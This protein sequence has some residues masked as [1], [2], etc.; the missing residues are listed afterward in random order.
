MKTIKDIAKELGLSV[1]TVSKA[2]NNKSDVKRETRQKVLEE[3][4]R[5]NYTPNVNARSLIKKK[6]NMVGLMLSDITDPS[7]SEVALGIEEVLS[8]SGYQLIYGNTFLEIKKEK[9]FLKS[10]LERKIDGIIMK[11]SN[12]NEELLNTINQLKIPIVFLRSLGKNEQELNIS[13][14]DVNHYQATY[15]VVEYLVK[16][17]HRNI[18]FIGMTK[19]SREEEDRFK[20]YSDCL[21]D[22]NINVS[23]QNITIPGTKIIDGGYGIRNLLNKNPNITAVFAA[24]DLLAIGALDWLKERNYIVPNDISVIGFDNLEISRLHIINLTTVDL[25]RKEMGRQAAE[26]LLDMLSSEAINKKEVKLDTQLIIRNTSGK[27]PKSIL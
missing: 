3:M 19:E 27:N 12:L 15:N 8:T 18:G 9:D 21:K 5:I 16:L 6:T 11:P 26:M 13:S 17:G 1:S 14:I 23:G 24:N 10:L 22:N 2:L 4:E 25:P 20:G 7:F